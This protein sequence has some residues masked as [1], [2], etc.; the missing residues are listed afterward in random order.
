MNEVGTTAQYEPDPRLIAPISDT[1]PAGADLSYDPDF[2]KLLAEIDKMTSLAG[3]LPDWHYVLAESER[4]LRE[5]SKDLRVMGWLVAAHAFTGGWNGIRLGLA[6]YATLTRSFWPTLFPPANRLRARAGQVEWLWGVLARRVAALPV[7]GADLEVARSLEPRIAELAAFFTENLKDA[8]PGIGSLRA[9]LREKLRA[10]AEAAPPPPPPL[11]SA[12]A[13]SVPPFLPDG[14]PTV[15][16]GPPPIITASIAASI[17]PSI[18]AVT[19]DAASLAGLEQTQDA[20]RALRDP[21]F[22]LAHHARRVAPAAGWPYRILRFAAWLTVERAPEA[23]GQKTPLRAPKGADR[24]LLANLQA[25]GQW[26]ALIEAAEDMAATHIL[27]LDPHRMTALALEQKGPEFRAARLA[28]GRE[29]AALVERVPGLTSLAFS[30]GTPFASPETVDWLAAEQA[31]FTKG[32]GNGAARPGGAHPS[33][34]DATLLAALDERLANGSPDEAF[35]T[36]LAEAEQ[37][38]SP[39]SR[40]RAHLAVARQAQIK[41]RLDVAYALYEQLILQV[42]ATLEQWEPALS[43]EALGGFLKVLRQLARN[44]KPGAADQDGHEQKEFSLF[45]RLLALDPHAALR[46]RA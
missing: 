1:Q 3:Q 32:G 19:V 2:E 38:V 29:I 4:T 25:N 17:A 9:A 46:S 36:T 30:N 41:D 45:R 31:R 26:D 18:A 37:L 7:D 34:D 12:A 39:R 13:P 23:E 10:L 11:A 20:A 6:S 27:W 35:A 28:V 42:D 43:A 15:S 16:A 14:A 8:D 24:E 33:E 21:L 44:R 22:T 40:F 5:K